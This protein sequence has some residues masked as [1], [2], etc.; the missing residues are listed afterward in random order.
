MDTLESLRIKPE[1]AAVIDAV[2]KTFK[3]VAASYIGQY[4]ES[5]SDLKD[6]Y[7]TVSLG[8]F[9]YFISKKI[10]DYENT[11]PSKATYNLI[12]IIVFGSDQGLAGRF[13]DSLTDYV[14][15]ALDLMVC[16]TK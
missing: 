12:C 14:S 1:S 5:A 6:Y 16:G 7:K 11:R 8:L 4:E 10:S 2:V 13:N 9:T 15:Q 3:A